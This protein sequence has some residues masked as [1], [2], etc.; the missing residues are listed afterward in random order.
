[1]RSPLT[2]TNYDLYCHKNKQIKLLA[3]INDGAHSRFGTVNRPG[4]YPNPIGK[5]QM[6]KSANI[7]L[8]PDLKTGLN[9]A[10]T[11]GTRSVRQS[12]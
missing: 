6:R 5:C 2:C 3:V 9:Y 7:A 4:K 10:A 11:I 1:M 12:A 8:N